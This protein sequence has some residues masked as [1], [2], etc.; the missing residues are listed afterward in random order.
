MRRNTLRRLLIISGLLLTGSM[1]GYSQ[2]NS[3]STGADGALDLATMNCPSPTGACYVQLPESGILNYTTI[4]IPSGKT[5]RFKLN[6]R[7]TPAYLL[8]QGAITINGTIDVSPTTWGSCPSQGPEEYGP[9][10]FRGGQP[11][12]PGFG[13][14]AGQSPNEHGRW[15]GP[16]SLVP[17]VGGSGGTGTAAVPNVSG[18]WVGGNG[19]GAI[20]IASSTS[21]TGNGGQ[22]YA[23]GDAHWACYTGPASTWGSGGAIRMVSPSIV[24]SGAVNACSSWSSWRSC[25]VIRLEATSLTFTGSSDPMAVSAPINPVTISGAIPVLAISSVG[26]YTVPSYA[27]AH[28]DLIDL[29][30]PNQIPD[31]VNVVVSA[32]NIPTGTQ[33]QVGFVSGSPNGTSTPCNLTG[34]FDNSSCTATI[35]NLNRTGGT[36]LLAT[37]AFTPPASLARY[38]PKG[39]DQVAKVRLNSAIAAKPTYAFLR[40][41]GSIIDPKRL[42]PKFLVEF[43]M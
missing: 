18:G 5:L 38:N 11:G 4:N 27:G 35:S 33:V 29:L 19:G 37:A 41:D 26:G 2:F 42:S 15:I 21:I 36:Y 10:G 7:N 1:R 6:S 22:I 12:M 43:G 28:F 14:G 23:T 34:S 40:S 31:P 9:G 39:K 32:Q 24:F 3:G 25:G 17:L 13:P 16:L 30:L 8:A 20:L